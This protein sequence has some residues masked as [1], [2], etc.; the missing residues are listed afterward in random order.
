MHSIEQSI[1][2]PELPCVRP[3]FEASYFH[4][5]ARYTHGHNGPPIVRGQPRVEWSRDWRC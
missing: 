2:S 5:G 4:N 1:K 3:S